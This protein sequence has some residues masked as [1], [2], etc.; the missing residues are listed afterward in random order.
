MKRKRL[1]YQLFLSF[2]LI[3]VVSL[4]AVTWY[5]SS[6][7]REFFLKEVQSDM[8]TRAVLFSRE[9]EGLFD[10][11]REKEIDSLCKGVGKVISTRFTVVLPSG[12]VVGD[13][14]EAPASMDNH[15]DRP[16]IL[17]ALSGRP[18]GYLRYSITLERGMMYMAVPLE[19]GG[20]IAAAVRS[21]I[22]VDTIDKA[23]RGV[24]VKIGL[25]G[26]IIAAIAALLSLLLSRRVRRP[27]DEIRRGAESFARGDFQFRLPISELEEMS[28]LS[29]TMNRM[30]AELQERILTITRQRNE[31]EAVLSSM[32]EGVVAL[33][34]Q[35]H[36]VTMNRA[37]GQLFDCKPAEVLGASIQEVVRNTDLQRFVK[38]TF[39]AQGPLVTDL[40]FCAS[41]EEKILSVLGTGLRDPEGRR[42]G[43]L[44]VLNDVTRLRKLET[45]RKDFVANV[46]HEIRTPITAIKGSVETLLDAKEK[47]PW[48]TDRFLRIIEKHADRLEAIVE[49]LLSLSR[50]EGE[51]EKEEI[52]LKEEKLKDLLLS[53]IQLCESKAQEKG[54]IL[55]L[56]CEEDLWAKINPALLEQAVVNLIDNAIKYSEEGGRV[57]VNAGEADGEAVIR[58]RDEGCGIEKQ[59]LDRLFERFYRVDKARSRKLGGTGLGLAIVK[60]ITDAHRGKVHV[61]SQPGKGSTFSIHLPGSLDELTHSI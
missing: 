36:I 9:V 5:A 12:R 34:G 24:Q 11:L 21:S 58:V 15:L 25:A 4:V 56:S 3:T 41:D 28:A 31:L 44:I 13:S 50:I 2:L 18:G 26:M 8:E 16:E 33:D 55:D 10:P 27:I 49:D 57:R 32:V 54:I 46:S 19:Q 60:H 1:L 20:R 61:E 7:L 53:A 22:P 23:L 51:A 30:A 29:E 17:E 40:R 6:S 59:H 37:A 35:E 43:A 14:H 47:E 42:M 45:I 38:E 48:D 52:P 39:A